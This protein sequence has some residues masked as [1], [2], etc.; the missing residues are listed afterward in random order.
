MKNMEKKRRLSGN[1]VT[2]LMTAVIAAV[3]AGILYSGAASR[4]MSSMLVSM[5]CYIA[6][7]VSL[8]LVVGLLGELSLGHA[9][10]MSAGLFTGCLFSLATADSLPLIVRLPAA[11]LIGGLAAALV[12]LIVGL[13]ALRLKGDYLAIVTLGCGEII[14]SIITNLNVTG[15]AKGLNTGAIYA[16]TKTLLPY[17]IVLVFLVV[18]VMMNLKN[19]RHGRAIMAIRDNRIAAESNGVNV[20]Y[21]KLM[22]FIIAAFFAGMAGVL[23]GHTLA[24]IK[25]AMFDYNMSI[26]ILVI[27]V[28]GGMGLDPR[29]DHRDDYP[30]R[31]A[32]GA[33]RGGGLPDARVFGAADR[34]YAAQRVAEVCRAEGPLVRRQYPAH[35]QGKQ[36]EGGEGKWLRSKDRASRCPI[37]R[38]CRIPVARWCRSATWTICPCSRRATSASTSA[39]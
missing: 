39:A 5:T 12:G 1:A 14:K 23:Y 37:P 28:L 29:L 32:R 16:D 27:V 34:D 15:G 35:A 33:A 19:S 13:P 38:L 24:N 31:A 26:E 10:F 4:Q 11:M 25:P 2:L 7:A 9:G 3:C 30:A 6:M 17:G 36:G 8:N 21:Y 22:V 20:T 18:I